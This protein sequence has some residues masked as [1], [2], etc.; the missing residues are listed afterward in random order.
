[1]VAG[2]TAN[3]GGGSGRRWRDTG[4]D[5][6]KEKPDRN[7]GGRGGSGYAGAAICRHSPAGRLQMKHC[8]G[9]LARAAQRAETG[10]PATESEAN[11]GSTRGRERPAGNE[12]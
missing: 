1:M 8:K 6:A 2:A 12:V 11:G 3:L 4:S 10:R 9:R 7:H 5:P